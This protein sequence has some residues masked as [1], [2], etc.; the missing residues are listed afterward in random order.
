MCANP[1]LLSAKQRPHTSAFSSSS[2]FSLRRRRAGASPS[3]ASGRP[4]PSSPLIF[5][6]AT[7]EILAPSVD[8]RLMAALTAACG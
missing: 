1:A 6:A 4:L 7:G 5:A 8:A 3:V 2:S